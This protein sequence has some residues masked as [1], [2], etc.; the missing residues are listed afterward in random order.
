MH[1]KTPT[2][3]VYYPPLLSTAGKTISG[4]VCLPVSAH[5]DIRTHTLC[6]SRPEKKYLISPT[7]VWNGDAG[8]SEPQLHLTHLAIYSQ[9]LHLCSQRLLPAPR[10]DQVSQM[11][12]PDKPCISHSKVGTMT[13]Q[14][15]FSRAP[16]QHAHIF[17]DLSQVAQYARLHKKMF[18]PKTSGSSTGF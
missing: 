1:Q 5:T 15:G 14:A 3:F 17:L 10:Q 11:H 16:T 2:Y 6:N 7:C 4:I 12:V 8:S 9:I 18:L 13:F